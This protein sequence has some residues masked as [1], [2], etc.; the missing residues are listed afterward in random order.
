MSNLTVIYTGGLYGYYRD[1]A[2]TFNIDT[3]LVGHF[4]RKYGG[5]TKPLLLGMGDN[6]GPEFGASIQDKD[7]KAPGSADFKS[8]CALDYSDE[9]FPQALYKDDLR[10]AKSAACDNVAH[11]LLRAGYRALVPGREDFMYGSGWLRT[12]ALNLGIV[13]QLTNAT[14]DG[15]ERP[16]NSDHQLYMLAANVRLH[17]KSPGKSINSCPLL[18]AREGLAPGGAEGGTPATC[19]QQTSGNPPELLD[20]LD[21][22]TRV[23]QNP[24]LVDSLA[25]EATYPDKETKNATE[26]QQRVTQHRNQLIVNQLDELRLMA[27]GIKGNGDLLNSI[28]GLQT[29]LK[30]SAAVF[31]QPNELIGIC[32][33][34]ESLAGSDEKGGEEGCKSWARQACQ[35]SAGPPSSIPNPLTEAGEIADLKAFAN[36]LLEKLGTLCKQTTKSMSKLK[37]DE[38]IV[39]E[40]A[41]E[42]GVQALLRAIAREQENIGYTVTSLGSGKQGTELIIGVVGESTLKDVSLTNRSFCLK[43]PTESAE[44]VYCD[45]RARPRDELKVDTAHPGKEAKVEAEVYVLNPIKTIVALMRAAQLEYPAIN[46]VIVMAQ[47]PHTDAEEL[48]AALRAVLAQQCLIGPCAQER[49]SPIAFILSKAE[50]EHASG[51]AE[52]HVY[53]EPA[54]PPVLTPRRAYST[55]QEECSPGKCP[56]AMSPLLAD[57]AS[58]VTFTSCSV[59]EGPSASGPACTGG[60]SAQNG[61]KLQSVVKNEE[62]DGDKALAPA[63]AV[64]S[65]VLLA[66]K[67]VGIPEKGDPDPPSPYGDI[68]VGRGA[69]TAIV[70]VADLLRDGNCFSAG[71]QPSH[72]HPIENGNKG[73]DVAVMRLLLQMLGRGARARRPDGVSE[74]LNRAGEATDVAMLEGRDIWMG[75]LPEGYASPRDLCA[76]WI[77]V[78]QFTDSEARQANCE[79]RVALDVILWKGD[80]AVRVEAKGSDLTDMMATAQKLSAGEANLTSHDVVGE[81][82]ATFG[83]A[84]RQ[85]QNL[86]TLPPSSTSFWIPETGECV[87]NDNASAKPQGGAGG[88]GG[89]TQGE[90]PVTYCVNGKTIQADAS[91]WI[92]TSDHLATD[93]AVYTTLGKLPPQDE[94]A[95]DCYLTEKIAQAFQAEAN[96]PRTPCSGGHPSQA[97]LA[98]RIK[99]RK[100]GPPLSAPAPRQENSVREKPIDSDLEA[101]EDMHQRRP[102]FHMEFAKVVA[103]FDTRVAVNGDSYVASNFQ[104]VTDSRASAPSQ[105]ELDLE[106]QMRGYI[107]FRKQPEHI[108]G[109]EFRVGI[110][111]DLEFDRSAQ[112]NLSGKAENPSFPLN[113]FTGGAFLEIH[114]LGAG[115]TLFVGEWLKRIPLTRMTPA[116][117]S[118]VGAPFQY[119]RQIIGNHLYFPFTSNADGAGPKNNSQL[120]VPTQPAYGWAE[121][122]G[123]R[124]SAAKPD[125]TARFYWDS[126]S[127][128]EVGVQVQNQRQVLEAL[129][130]N[131]PD[132]TAGPASHTCYA[133]GPANFATCMKTV[134][135]NGKN[136]PFTID[137]DS[138]FSK[139]I[140]ANPTQYGLYWDVSLAKQL[141]PANDQIH[142]VILLLASKGDRLGTSHLPLSSETRYDA[143]FSA[144]VAFQLLP[145][146][147]VSPSYNGFWY[148]NEV[149]NG[150]LF[151]NEGLITLRWFYN[152]DSLVPLWPQFRFGGPASND[153]TKSMHMSKGGS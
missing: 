84:Q 116:R 53:G 105:R 18:F 86:T 117:F 39:S 83:L 2:P 138:T 82:L 64:R 43:G 77:R 99:P 110:Q 17:L 95:T 20:V 22:M 12:M 145:N 89:T 113:S 30:S 73:C 72:D 143:P 45:D 140:Y 35:P 93:N 87:D 112:G 59:E 48:G 60:K 130:I 150:H 76:R 36:G 19:S 103:G 109:S 55:P 56:I 58:K 29:R 148:S 136:I 114:I 144:A 38:L 118:V 119:Q 74:L 26:V 79:L 70:T 7:L 63:L 1:D 68:R 108:V 91:Y 151:V 6:F 141:T 80:Y 107:R 146:L 10:V 31:P 102:M 121:R 100:P 92:V 62:V 13:S 67:L 15:S 128:W 4:I 8:N 61:K 127:Y 131:T 28:K 142:K 97:E 47:M 71:S 46:S 40:D 75:N 21:R 50:P 106:Q 23:L 5:E 11:F 52:L 124:E 57:P 66:D 41:R 42:K 78:A 98:R 65:S 51:E 153:Q 81:W 54:A 27:W 94:F 88:A 134:T 120:V 33:G 126:G 14:D 85:A 129:T 37:G 32:Q 25:S 137:A 44:L 9:G 111:S 104:G 139:P 122:V 3:E 24:Q 123:L 16:A 101:A 34:V 96:L 90:D 133:S 135:V 147:S 132:V 49:V 69:G 125:K 115:S 152:R 149:L